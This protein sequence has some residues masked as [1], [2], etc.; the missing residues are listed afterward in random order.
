ML[1]LV[2]ASFTGKIVHQCSQASVTDPLILSLPYIWCS[3]ATILWFS[4]DNDEP[5]TSYLLKNIVYC[6]TSR[7]LLPGPKLEIFLKTYCVSQ[8]SF[9][10]AFNTVLINYWLQLHE[11]VLF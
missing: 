3:L 1:N 5:V 6:V 11:I 10:G 7:L 8:L 2:Q 9:E 4:K